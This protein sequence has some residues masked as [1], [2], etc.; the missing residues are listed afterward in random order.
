MLAIRDLSATEKHVL[1]VLALRADI[2]TRRC[3]PSIATL[4]ADTGLTERSVQ[5]AM[6]SLK[7]AGHITR[8][9]RP[10][11]GLIYTVHPCSAASGLSETPRASEPRLTVTPD[12]ESPGHSVAEPPTQSHP[13]NQE[14]PFPLE[15]P[16][17]RRRLAAHAALIAVV[18]AETGWRRRTSTSRQKRG[19]WP[20]GGRQAHPKLKQPDTRNG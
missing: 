13:N 9:E 16:R 11:R 5:R 12:I 10:G 18:D 17:R 3:T 20:S 2:G 8:F 4:A 6:K 1:L 15:P 19:R 7:D 14:Q